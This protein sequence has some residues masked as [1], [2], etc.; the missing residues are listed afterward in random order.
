MEGERT[1]NRE[2]ARGIHEPGL[3]IRVTWEWLK[4]RRAEFLRLACRLA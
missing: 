1:L 3:I 2:P 4:N